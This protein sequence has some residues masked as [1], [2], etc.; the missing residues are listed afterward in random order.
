MNKEYKFQL[1]CKEGIY[2]ADSLLDLIIQV[3]RHRFW[4][5]MNDGKWMD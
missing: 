4:H 3:I 2:Y 5:L 1:H